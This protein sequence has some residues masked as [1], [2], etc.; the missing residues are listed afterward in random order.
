MLVSRKV[1]PLLDMADRLRS[2]AELTIPTMVL[3]RRVD[4]FGNYEPM[5]TTF[6]AGL[7][8]ETIIYCEVE[9]FSSNR[10]GDA[11]ETKLS[12]EAVLYTETGV[13]ILKGKDEVPTDESAQPPPR[14]L[15]RQ[16]TE[17]APG[18][19]ARRSTS[20][21]HHRRRAGQAGLGE[22][23]PDHDDGAVGAKC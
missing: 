21:G 6:K 8:H 23:R 18:R 4:G 10:N 3:C 1:K 11:W 12:M 19:S 16:A 13:A 2:Q 22:Q 7:D 5:A 14:L 17:A 15:R 20:E 9:N